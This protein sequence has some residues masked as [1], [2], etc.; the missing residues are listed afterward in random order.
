MLL[1]FWMVLMNFLLPAKVLSVSLLHEQREKTHRGTSCA[2]SMKVQALTDSPGQVSP[3]WS[4]QGTVS[5]TRGQ[6]QNE[7]I[8]GLEMLFPAYRVLSAEAEERAGWRL[9]W[10][11]AGP[12]KL[13]TEEAS[14]GL[15]LRSWK[16]L[17]WGPVQPLAC[18]VQALP[19]PGWL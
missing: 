9:S 18:S 16:Q 17:P 5:G 2:L 15:C 1:V 13:D 4:P 8:L 10:V 7:P 12:G 11:R 3:T 14:P 19:L 6:S